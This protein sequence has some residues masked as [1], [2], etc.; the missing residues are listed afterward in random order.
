MKRDWD[1]CRKILLKIEDEYIDTAIMNLTVEKY[2][3][4]VVAYHC[5]IMYEAGLIS[6]FNS[7]Y[8]DNHI[9]FFCVGGLTWEGH[10]FLEKIR[11]ESF[12]EKIKKEIKKNAVPLCFEGIK[13]FVTTYL[14][15]AFS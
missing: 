1:L 2:S 6:S 4:E 13:I 11:D 8:A 9:Y 7:K 12:F 3:K 10:E 14:Y 5:N 15:K